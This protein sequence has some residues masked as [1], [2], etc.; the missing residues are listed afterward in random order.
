MV[1]RSR[2]VVS[3]L[4]ALVGAGCAV[5]SPD[6]PVATQSAALS[7]R[8]LCRITPAGGATLDYSNLYSLSDCHALADRLAADYCAH[9]G[10]SIRGEVAFFNYNDCHKKDWS[11]SW[12]CYIWWQSSQNWDRRQREWSCASAPAPAP[13]GPVVFY[14][15]LDFSGEAVEL[16]GE[17]PFVGWNWNDRITS[18]RIPAGK[19]VVLY[20]HDWFRGASVT[21]TGDQ[22]DLRTLGFN[23]SASSIRVY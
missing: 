4:V 2:A 18:I 3:V 7:D 5:E 20:E 1:V 10:S 13:S 19:T 17:V 6:E 22:P 21:L 12:G 11:V 15:H 8:P 16:A 14:E 9:G 23:D